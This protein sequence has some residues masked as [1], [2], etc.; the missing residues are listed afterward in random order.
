MRFL[1]NSNGKNQLKDFKNKA[2]RDNTTDSLDNTFSQ[3]ALDSK[4]TSTKRIVYDY[5]SPYQKSV[6][7][8]K[9]FGL[10]FMALDFCKTIKDQRK[11]QRK[12][13]RDGAL[14]QNNPK[15]L[16]EVIKVLRKTEKRSE[17]DVMTIMPI[18]KVMKFF[19]EVVHMNDEELFEIA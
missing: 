12:L 3:T 1:N 7:L 18:L 13:I 14:L 5:V 10:A 17:K 8:T 19:K 6:I 16:K 15:R 9:Y 2:S 11:Q 4:T